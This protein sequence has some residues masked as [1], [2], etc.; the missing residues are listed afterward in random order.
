MSTLPRD[1]APES[2]TRQL[3]A[4]HEAY[5]EAINLAV[6]ADDLTLVDELSRDFDRDALDLMTRRLHGHAA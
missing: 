1:A 5:V 3:T 4:L 2:L 6:A